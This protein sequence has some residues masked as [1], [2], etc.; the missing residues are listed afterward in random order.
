MLEYVDN[1]ARKAM[2]ELIYKDYTIE[3]KKT[4]LYGVANLGIIMDWEDYRNDWLQ[5]KILKPLEDIKNG[6]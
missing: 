2:I 3:K 5:K 6:K 4:C 1:E